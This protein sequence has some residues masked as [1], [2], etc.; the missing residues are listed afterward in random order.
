[1]ECIPDKEAKAPPQAI[2]GALIFVDGKPVLVVTGAIGSNPDLK[3]HMLAEVLEAYE[4]ESGERIDIDHLEWSADHRLDA[5]SI[6]DLGG[7]KPDFALAEDGRALAFCFGG[8]AAA[9]EL[10]AAQARTIHRL[11]L[12]ALL[13]PLTGIANR[14][15][16]GIRLQNCVHAALRHGH[17][18][19]VAIIDLDKFKSYNQSGGYR[20]GDD[21]LRQWAQFLKASLRRDDFIARYGGD[22]FLLLLPMTDQRAAATVFERLQTKLAGHPLRE[23][24][25]LTF[26]AGAASLEEMPESGDPDSLLTIAGQRLLEAKR[27]RPANIIID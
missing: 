7:A 3:A 1:M 14:R 15:H 6:A 27:A 23:K 10:I 9:P 2:G 16:A 11:R 5:E 12:E 18:L 4:A 21:L 24:F 22:E 17:A 8:L 20:L 13:D 25:G 26:S 19:T